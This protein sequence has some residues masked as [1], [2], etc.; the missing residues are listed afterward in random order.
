M[1]SVTDPLPSMD[2]SWVQFPE[3]RKIN[4]PQALGRVLG[5]TSSNSRKQY[6]KRRSKPPAHSPAF[7]TVWPRAVS[8]G[9]PLPL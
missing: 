7:G 2:R 3:L 8:E 4:Q 5:A 1:V 6:G 9:H